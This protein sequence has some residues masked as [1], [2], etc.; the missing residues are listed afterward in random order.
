MLKELDFE[1]FFKKEQPHLD[2]NGLGGVG[3]ISPTQSIQVINVAGK[4]KN[5]EVM[6]G[7][8]LHYTTLLYI[9]KDMF[10]IEYNDKIIAYDVELYRK[11]C[12]KIPY[13]ENN[14]ITFRYTVNK[15][16]DEDDVVYPFAGIS[17]P[18]YINPYQ[19]EELERINDILKKLY[20]NTQVEITEYNPINSLKEKGEKQYFDDEENELEKAIEYLKNNNR[21][22]EYNLPIEEQIV[23]V[24][25]NKKRTI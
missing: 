21:V 1:N 5:K 13:A 22:V 18:K 20:V 8:G 24:E 25:H 10:N 2:E 6:D 23:K 14:L 11:I 3:V 12:E 16:S 15:L 19:L 17:I 7:L 4:N 9:L